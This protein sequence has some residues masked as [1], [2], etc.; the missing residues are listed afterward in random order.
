MPTV[1]GMLHKAKKM[2]GK[3]VSSPPSPPPP[4]P[5]RR[6]L[7]P[8]PDVLWQWMDNDADVASSGDEWKTYTLEQSATIDAAYNEMLSSPPIW[9]LQTIWSRGEVTSTSITPKEHI[10]DILVAVEAG[11]GAGAATPTR[12]RSAHTYATKYRIDLM[13]MVQTNMSTGASREIQRL[14]PASHGSLKG[15]PTTLGGA[16][17]EDDGGDDDGDVYEPF[18]QSQPALYDALKASKQHYDRDEHERNRRAA[19]Q[20]AAN[21]ANI[22]NIVYATYASSSSLVG[23]ARENPRPSASSAPPPSPRQRQVGH[24]SLL[25]TERGDSTV[26]GWP[27]CTPLIL[28]N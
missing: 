17:A 1:A 25:E 22:A 16:A 27:S 20:S 8:T 21:N 23:G 18:D 15:R 12:K 14:L 7:P 11:A 19:L 4:P 5:R 28:A 13:Q 10:V 2:V 9:K 26:Q 3:A 24:R 6:P